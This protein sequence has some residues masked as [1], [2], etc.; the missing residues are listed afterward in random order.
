M[1]SDRAKNA[2]QARWRKSASNAQATPKKNPNIAQIMHEPCSS[3]S[4]FEEKNENFLENS[5]WI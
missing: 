2:A 3:S 5:K 4:N 1:K